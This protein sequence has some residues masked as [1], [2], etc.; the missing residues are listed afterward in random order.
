MLDFHGDGPAPLPPAARSQLTET[1]TPAHPRR[2]AQRR[3][4][5]ASPAG[6]RRGGSGQAWR[7]SWSSPGGRQSR[8]A[9]HNQR[10]ARHT[11]RPHA[12]GSDC[13]RAGAAGFTSSVQGPGGLAP[14]GSAGC[15]VAWS[16]F[17]TS[18]QLAGSCRGVARKRCERLDDPISEMPAAVTGIACV[19][20]GKGPDRDGCDHRD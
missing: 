13:V 19:T 14:Y 5:P 3:A 18:C 4:N 20:S 15:A 10:L 9:S 17:R 16:G 8:A 1:T 11:A 2:T 6:G 12:Y 7:C